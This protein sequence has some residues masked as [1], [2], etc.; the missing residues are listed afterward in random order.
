[1]RPFL[2]ETY[3]DATFR[4]ARFDRF[5]EEFFQVKLKHFLKEIN[6]LHY[7]CSQTCVSETAV[8]SPCLKS[9]SSLY[10]GFFNHVEGLLHSRLATFPRCL[11]DCTSLPKD[12]CCDQCIDSTIQL[13]RKIDPEKELGRFLEFSE[14]KAQQSTH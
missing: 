10:D 3:F 6:R 9:C 14:W 12:Q 11:D 13:L 1:M 5:Y 8:D 4:E 7:D 2:S